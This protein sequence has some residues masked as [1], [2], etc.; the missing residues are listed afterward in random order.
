VVEINVL[1]CQ[2]SAYGTSL[3]PNVL[4]W[5]MMDFFS[6]PLAILAAMRLANPPQI[7]MRSY[8]EVMISVII[9]VSMTV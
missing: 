5:T 4:N 3:T 6:V 1:W 8:I 9:I 7:T 2:Q